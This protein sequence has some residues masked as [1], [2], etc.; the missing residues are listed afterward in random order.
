MAGGEADIWIMIFKV[1][2][3]F[4]NNTYHPLFAFDLSMNEWMKNSIDTMQFL[5][6]RI[7]KPQ[8]PP[9]SI[10]QWC[11]ATSSG[12]PPSHGLFE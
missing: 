11:V 12:N 6:G 10:T 4:E 5:W 7:T 3:T 9:T 1:H 8:L 2:H